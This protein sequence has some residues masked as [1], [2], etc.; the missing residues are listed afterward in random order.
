MRVVYLV[1][2]GC[3]CAEHPKGEASAIGL[4][5][6]VTTVPVEMQVIVEAMKAVAR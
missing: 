3:Q 6:R 1:R 5:A 4:L 2:Y